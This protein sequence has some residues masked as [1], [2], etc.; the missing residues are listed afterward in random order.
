MRLIHHCSRRRHQPLHA[1]ARPAQQHGAQ[2]V[3]GEL[4][5]DEQARGAGAGSRVG[6]VHVAVVG[7]GAGPGGEGGVEEEGEE[8]DEGEG[9]EGE[10]GVAEEAEGE[11]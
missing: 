1:V 4:R 6:R 7:E 9:G 10:V 2:H 3:D 11:R 8:G 5:D